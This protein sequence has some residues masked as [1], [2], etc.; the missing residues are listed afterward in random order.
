MSSQE[1]KS[2]SET[3]PMRSLNSSITPK[4][5]SYPVRICCVV[6][7]LSD[8]DGNSL[9]PRIREHTHKAGATFTTRHYNS[10]KNSDDRDYV[11]R[12][13]AFHVYI[14][15]AHIKTFYS[16]TRPF[17]HIDESVE[18]YIKKLAAK[19]E[20]SERWRQRF[21]GFVQWM[22]GLVVRK[23]RMERYNEDHMVDTMAG[24]G[25]LQ[26]ISRN[27]IPIECWN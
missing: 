24:N 22:K 8:S 4:T 7:E 3:N 9:I 16:N 11:E 17:Q 6:D 18:R 10:R 21:T 19:K 14:N 2:E 26:T 5:E 25:R 27:T 1:A 20:R 12:L 15:K 13:P 23:T